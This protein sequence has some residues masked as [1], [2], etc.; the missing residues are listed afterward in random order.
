MP[1][2]PVGRHASPIRLSMWSGPR[3]VSTALMYAF[4]QRSDTEVVDEPLY[5]H[6]LRTSGLD[7]PGRREVMAAM[8]VDGARVVHEVLLESRTSTPVRFFKN[9][10]HHLRGLDRGFLDGLTNGLLTRDPR[11]MLPSLARQLPHPTLADTGFAEQVELLEREEEAGRP[12]LVLDARELLLDPEGVL[13]E[14]C[15]RL[16]L[17]FE[18]AMLRWPPGPKPEDG[19]WAPYWYAGV[20]ASTGFAPYRPQREP[21]PEPLRPLLDACLPHYERLYAY[22]IRAYA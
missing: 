15:R 9:M 6:Y 17:A 20:H 4:R 12:P 11:E 14:A 2:P 16:G 8:D 3:N 19:A 10:A 21:F 7:H 13:S 22:A 5:G 1:E 18:P